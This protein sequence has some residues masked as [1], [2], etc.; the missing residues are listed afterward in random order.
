MFYDYIRWMCV[1]AVCVVTVQIYLNFA[2]TYLGIKFGNLS[3]QNKSNDSNQHTKIFCVDI[4]ADSSLGRRAKSFKENDGKSRLAYDSS[5][6]VSFI[7]LQRQIGDIDS[8][9]SHFTI[10]A[11][12]YKDYPLLV[13][14]VICWIRS[15]TTAKV[16]RDNLSLL[17]TTLS[18]GCDTN[19]KCS[20]G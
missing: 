19:L 9:F 12:V 6:F 3:F 13:I 11:I 2:S 7:C 20:N 4:R 17:L 5:P 14:A 18:S 16:S 15:W 1:Y 10:Y 8:D